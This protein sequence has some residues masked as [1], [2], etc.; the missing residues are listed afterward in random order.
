VIC[1]LCPHNC[2]LSEGEFGKC[3]VRQNFNNKII[4]TTH[5]KVSTVIEGPIEDKMI[6]HFYPGLKILSLGG[7]GCNFGCKFCQNFEISQSNTGKT[8]PLTAKEAIA[9]ALAN[10]CEGIAFAYSEPFVWYEYVC[11]VAE[12]AKKANLKTILKTNGYANPIYFGKMLKLM[13]AVNIDIKGVPAF[14]R[15]ITGV[16]LGKNNVIFENIRQC[17]SICH[18]E[19]CVLAF[20][21]YCELHGMA[22]LFKGILENTH[23]SLPIHILKFIP[24]Y[25][26]QYIIPTSDDILDKVEQE[27]RKF[28]YYVYVE[29]ANRENPTLCQKCETVLVERN[30]SKIV[31]HLNGS[32]CP[33]C[34]ENGPIEI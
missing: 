26:S 6:Y 15:Q 33:K 19:V 5:N 13:D 27:A 14:Y 30:G 11:G 24:A 22:S 28:F 12:L 2:D 8:K 25:K 18:T 10:E 9:C 31:S 17:V 1:D 29:Y 32:K 23:K 3:H 16:E 21:T 4:L 7:L 20:P 34:L